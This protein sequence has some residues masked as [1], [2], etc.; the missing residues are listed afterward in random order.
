MDQEWR[1]TGENVLFRIK[2]LNRITLFFEVA[3]YAW[4]LALE[5]K[6]LKLLNRYLTMKKTSIW[7]DIKLLS[8]FKIPRFASYLDPK[9]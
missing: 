4:D 9:E 5:K 3:F 7:K 8:L 6:E 2:Q 1:L